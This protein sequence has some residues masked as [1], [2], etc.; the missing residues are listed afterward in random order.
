MRNVLTPMHITFTPD[1][2]VLHTDHGETLSQS[3]LW[4]PALREASD[5]QR[6]DYTLSLDG[7]HWRALDTDISYESFRYPEAEP[8]PMQ[9]FFLTHRELNLNDI[10]RRVGIQ[11][12]RLRA[13][14]NG[15]KQ[16]TPECETRIMQ[17]IMLR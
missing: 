17:E 15:I 6:A 1:H 3:L 4:Y 9:R 2:I 10:A 8:T 7:I 5:S 12:A 16:P 14:I 11:V 13:Y